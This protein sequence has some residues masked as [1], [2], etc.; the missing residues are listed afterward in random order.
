ML[1][2]VLPTRDDAGPPDLLMPVLYPADVG[3][4]LAFGVQTGRIPE[5]LARRE[6]DP[7]VLMLAAG[8]PGFVAACSQSALRSGVRADSIISEAYVRTDSH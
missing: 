7:D 6:I 3:E 1:Q 8:S 5:R 4:L 2:G